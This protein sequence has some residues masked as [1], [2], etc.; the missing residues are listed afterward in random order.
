MTHPGNVY[1][2]LPL[3]WVVI[4]FEIRDHIYISIT[5]TVLML[6]IPKGLTSLTRTL[7]QWIN[8]NFITYSHS[9]DWLLVKVQQRARK[10]SSVTLGIHYL[11]STRGRLC[12]SCRPRSLWRHWWWKTA[13][14]R[15]SPPASSALCSCLH[16][17][18]LKMERKSQVQLVIVELSSSRFILELFNSINSKYIFELTYYF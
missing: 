4:P 9:L 16:L 11:A 3:L 2:D 13:W 12:R 17:K 18:H 6:H 8:G 15:R 14:W 7:N 10:I 1:L 5:N